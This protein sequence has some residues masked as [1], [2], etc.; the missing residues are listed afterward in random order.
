[1][2]TILGES[3]SVLGAVACSLASSPTT[4]A[5]TRFVVGLGVGFCTLCKPLYISETV[6]SDR[7]GTVLALFAPSVAVGILIA[8][9]TPLLLPAGA[10]ESPISVAT[11][12]SN[13]SL[14]GALQ[15]GWRTRPPAC[16]GT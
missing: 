8:E 3:L 14:V 16:R 15:H 4:L 6:L 2:S 9:A 1:M 7:R 13:A 10:A 11:G 12:A 5:V